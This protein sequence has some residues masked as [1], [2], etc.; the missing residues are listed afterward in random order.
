[1]VLMTCRVL[2]VLFKDHPFC[3]EDLEN[4]RLYCGTHPLVFLCRIL[5]CMWPNEVQPSCIH[6]SPCIFKLSLA[7]KRKLYFFVICHETV[8]QK[9][10]LWSFLFHEYMC[11]HLIWYMQIGA[12]SNF[13][14][15]A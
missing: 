9:F 7:F 14:K 12:S 3:S 2:R 13:F 6:M 11:L 1:L 8:H 4:C 5:H 15:D 10:T